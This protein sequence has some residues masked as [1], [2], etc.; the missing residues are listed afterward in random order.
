MAKAG[1]MR[2]ATLCNFA[3][4][5]TIL[6]FLSFMVILPIT[7]VRAPVGFELRIMISRGLEFAL[8]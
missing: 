7:N 8:I 1:V 3:R 6:Q 5:R 4:L 2:E